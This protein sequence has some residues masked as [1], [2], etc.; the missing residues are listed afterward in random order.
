MWH[1]GKNEKL[2]QRAQMISFS[3]T[4]LPPGIYNL[5]SFLT[6]IILHSWFYCIFSQLHSNCSFVWL[7]SWWFYLEHDSWCCALLSLCLWK[8]AL[9]QSCFSSW[10][11]LS[12]NMQHCASNSLFLSAHSLL[13]CLI[14]LPFFDI[15]LM[16]ATEK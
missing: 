8:D 14:V 12:C 16:C 11:L 4:V 3:D 13:F 2:I 15:I 1:L 9:M 5:Y 10:L 7:P 6:V